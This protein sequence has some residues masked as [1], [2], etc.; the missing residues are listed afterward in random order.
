MRG[1]RSAVGFDRLGNRVAVLAQPI[2]EVGEVADSDDDE[3]AANGEQRLELWQPRA[4]S[5]SRGGRE[6]AILAVH[7]AGV[8][9]AVALQAVARR[10][11]DVRAP[12]HGLDGSAQGEVL[13]STPFLG[14]TTT[15]HGGPNYGFT[16]DLDLPW[17]VANDEKWFSYRRPD[18]RTNTTPVGCQRPY[19]AHRSDRFT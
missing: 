7:Q 16:C 6:R 17:Y 10:G 14:T 1:R 3:R 4:V 13:G 15:W 19:H 5:L 12:T 9:R 11:G 18:G 8:A 2:A